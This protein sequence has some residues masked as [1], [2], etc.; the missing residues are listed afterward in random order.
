MTG[1]TFI[2][3]GIL[4]TFNN[5]TIFQRASPSSTRYSSDIPDVTEN[6]GRHDASVFNRA[7]AARPCACVRKANDGTPEHSDAWFEADLFPH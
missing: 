1:L 6:I 3:T 7:A 5:K 2:N 4:M